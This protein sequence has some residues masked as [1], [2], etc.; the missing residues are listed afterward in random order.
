MVILY[1]YVYTRLVNGV[2]LYSQRPPPV[3]AGTESSVPKHHHLRR[4]KSPLEAVFPKLK[5][6]GSKFRLVYLG[7]YQQT[8]VLPFN[9]RFN[10]NN[11][12]VHIRSH[13]SK[14][15]YECCQ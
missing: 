4:N 1:L 15:Y 3:V 11:Y 10:K 14:F 8:M 9:I 12:K 5:L 6:S 13:R 2:T 7:L